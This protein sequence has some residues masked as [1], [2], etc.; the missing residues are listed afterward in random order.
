MMAEQVASTGAARRPVYHARVVRMVDHN[1]DTRSLILRLEEGARL[2]FVPGQFI[3]ISLRLPDE[4]RVRPYTI[5]S[6]PEEAAEAIELCFNQVPGGVGVGYLF[7]RK[8]GDVLEFTGPFGA[9]TMERAPE[10]ECVFI[11]EGTAIAPVRPM[12]RRALSAA[13]R[14]RLHLLY[15]APDEHHLLYRDEIVRWEAAGLDYTALIAPAAELYDRLVAEAER[16]WVAADAERG[17]QF[18]V[19]GV[20]KGVLRLRDLLRGAGYERRAVRY[21]QW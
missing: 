17:R 1:A 5:A 3:S 4:T 19:C 21:E 13:A 6:S 14:P 7:E 8:P 10:R 20:G 11:A 16:R 9:F 18:Y 15:A 2:A 12:I